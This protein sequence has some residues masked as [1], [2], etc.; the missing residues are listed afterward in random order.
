MIYECHGHIIADGDSYIQS[1][2]RHK[3]GINEPYVHEALQKIS[4]SGISFYR[5]GG[6][7]YN[8]SAYA[9]KIAGEYGVD[10]RT[11]HI[12]HP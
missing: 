12:Y 2:K 10:Y 6:D 8:V 11:P 3:F 4:E 7:K 9:K 5:D 1:M